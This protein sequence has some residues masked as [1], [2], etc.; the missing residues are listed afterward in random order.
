[1]PG[2]AGIGLPI[3]LIEI[4]VSYPVTAA[5]REFESGRYLL[6]S[7]ANR[8]VPSAHMTLPSNAARPLA[9][10]FDLFTPQPKSPV[11]TSVGNVLVMTS[12]CTKE[13]GWMSATRARPM[14]FLILIDT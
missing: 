7:L 13:R 12:E 10:P 6:L 5:A 8:A 4:S 11:V 14:T 9:M 3:N 1:M 2:G